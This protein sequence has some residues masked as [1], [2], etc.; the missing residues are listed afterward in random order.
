MEELKGVSGRRVEEG[1][2]IEGGIMIS[3]NKYRGAVSMSTHSEHK[4]SII[5]FKIST[6]V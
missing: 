6:E 4:R 2:G 3:A 1:G 5:S